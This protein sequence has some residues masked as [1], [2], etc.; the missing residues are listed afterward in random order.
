MSS[1]VAAIPLSDVALTLAGALTILGS[2]FAL[3]SMA[4]RKDPTPADHLAA[5]ALVALGIGGA[6]ACWQTAWGTWWLFI[7]ALAAVAL[8]IA[9]LTL[10]G[11]HTP[12][13]DEGL[14]RWIKA[15]GGLLAVPARAA[16]EDDREHH[17]RREQE[18]D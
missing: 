10:V 15:R 7:V 13:E 14:Y 6:L 3:G 16:G 12:K 8:L 17:P 9:A 11:R 4:L 2:V 1:P 5:A 18:D